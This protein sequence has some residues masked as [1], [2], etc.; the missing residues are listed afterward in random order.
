ML[1][2]K[3]SFSRVQHGSNNAPMGNVALGTMKAVKLRY[4]ISANVSIGFEAVGRG[5]EGGL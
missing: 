4:C 5:N 3:L 2:E 1:G